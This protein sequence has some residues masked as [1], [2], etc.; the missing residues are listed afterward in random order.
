MKY[1][2]LHTHHFLI[3]MHGQ[4]L[5]WI[6]KVSKLHETYFF[7][8]FIQLSCLRVSL[9]RDGEDLV[10]SSGV[11]EGPDDSVLLPAVRHP[12]G[13]WQ[14]TVSVDGS[15]VH[16]ASCGAVGIIWPLPSYSWTSARHRLT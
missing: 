13:L 12:T 10:C 7:K 11:I 15:L 14:G 3:L 6:E 4:G 5:V 2:T 8:P 9:L 1:Y 16:R